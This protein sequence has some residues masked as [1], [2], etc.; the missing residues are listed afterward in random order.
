MQ[1]TQRIN[2][3]REKEHCA[4]NDPATAFGNGKKQRER[5]AHNENHEIVAKTF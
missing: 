4:A 3:A 2:L 1:R 5:P